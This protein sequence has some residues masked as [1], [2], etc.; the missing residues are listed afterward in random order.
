MMV[1]TSLIAVD[2]LALPEM[3]LSREKSRAQRVCQYPQVWY[4]NLLG[5]APGLLESLRVALRAFFAL[6]AAGVKVRRW[7]ILI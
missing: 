5:G 3:V 1:R 7:A 6:V 2:V 4:E